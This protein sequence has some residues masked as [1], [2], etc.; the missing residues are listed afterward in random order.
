M[1][2]KCTILKETEKAMLTALPE[3]EDH[4]A[5]M[6][7]SQCQIMSDDCIEI[8]EWLIEKKWG[9][10][11][12]AALDADKIINAVAQSAV[13]LLKAGSLETAQKLAPAG[14]DLIEITR[15]EQRVWAAYDAAI[16]SAK[17]AAEMLSEKCGHAVRILGRNAQTGIIEMV[18]DA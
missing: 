13:E 6:P 1:K 4:A 14:S 5:W 11:I 15:G 10:G 17:N 18:V 16:M 12:L 2:I 9:R 7:K 8:P 3:M